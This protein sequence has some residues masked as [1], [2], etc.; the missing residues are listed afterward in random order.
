MGNKQYDV[1]IAGGGLA[2]LSCG[3]ALSGDH[4]SIPLRTLIIDAG[5]PFEGR[6]LTRD[7]RGTAIVESSRRMFEVLGIWDSIAKCAQPFEDI[8]VTDGKR[9]SATSPVLLHFVPQS[10]DGSAKAWMFENPV[11]LRALVEAVQKCGN[12]D[13]LTG[14]NVTSIVTDA[15]GITV[16]ANDTQ[17]IR[18]SLVVAAD[19]RNSV[20]RK[21]AGIEV[22][23]WEYGQSAIATTIEHEL[24]HNGRAEEHF[25]AAGPLAILPL[26][27][28]RSSIVW[29]ERSE[30]IQRLVKLPTEDL[31][32]EFLKR[33]GDHLGEIRFAAPVASWPLGLQ[34]ARSFAAERLALIG[35]AAHVIHPIA[36][37]GFNLAL[38]DVAALAECAIRQV[39]LGMDPGNRAG[40]EGYETWR[41]SDTVLVAAACDGLNRLFSNDEEPARTL[42]AGRLEAG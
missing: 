41:R 29:T 34:V 31:V 15:S 38:R 9:G 20:L 33:T 17:S 36:G 3:L 2:G 26:S 35:D 1:I 25:R 14:A 30:E 16:L 18:C 21:A 22:V 24:P 8:V 39:E 27:G 19:G 42:A 11:L 12:I 28:N 5:P 7:S 6:D 40:L 37:L 23:G 10:R 13:I 32:A 4:L